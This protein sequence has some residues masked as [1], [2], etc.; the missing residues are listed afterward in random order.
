M[1][2][3]NMKNHKYWIA[4]GILIIIAIIILYPFS[5]FN[6]IKMN[7]DRSDAIKIAK[8]YLLQFKIQGE[9]VDNYDIEDFAVFEKSKYNYIQSELSGDQ[10][11]A[12]M[13]KNL[14]PVAMWRIMFHQNLPKNLSQYSFN[15]LLDAKGGVL[16][17]YRSIPDSVDLPAIT[18]DSA[19]ALITNDISSLFGEK[20]TGFELKTNK[21]SKQDRRIIHQFKWEKDLS[22]IDGTV[23]FSATVIGNK[24]GKLIYHFEIPKE[25]GSRFLAFEALFGTISVILAF[26]LTQFAF[27]IFIKKY[28]QGEVWLSLGR[29]LFI[30]Y[31][32]I[33]LIGLIN[34]YPS[35]GSEV[36]IG[37]LNLTM[38]KIIVFLSTGL[39]VYFVLSLLLFATWAVGESI[40]R[41]IWPD[42]LKAFDAFIKGKITS[43]HSGS[44]LMK[45]M[46]LGLGGNLIVLIYSI[47]L[48]GSKSAFISSFTSFKIFNGYLPALDIV[49]DAVTISLMSSIGITFFLISSTYNKWKNKWLS[50]LL[51]GIS[52]IL[53]TVI[54]YTPPSPQILWIGLLGDF[55][56]GIILA[57]IFFRFD[58]LTLISFIF[59]M[60]ISSRILALAAGTTAFYEINL[61]FIL[62][63]ALSVPVI[64]VISRIKKYEFVVENFGLPS[65][66]QKI[67]E[68]ERLRKEM[69]IA[70]KV[71]LSLLPKEQ[72]KLKNY[73]I[74][75]LS[76][77]AKEAGG[78]Y[79]DFVTLS[80]NK[81]GIAIGDVSGK[82]VGAAIYMTLT[83][84]ILQA[85]AEENI[86]PKNVLAKV[87]KLLYKT[88]EKNSFVSMFYSILDIDKHSLLY[89]RAGHNP[90]IF[91]S[92]KSEGAHYLMSKGIALGLEEGTIFTNTLNEETIQLEAG[93]VI[94]LYTD[95]FTE[96]MNEKREL[97]GE[98]RF[99]KLIQENKY[100][101]A[102]QILD[103]IL[104]EVHKFTGHHPQHDD[105]TIVVL[106]RIN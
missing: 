25:K 62:I 88:I 10:F 23:A 5:S 15:V 63:L 50:I 87:N 95:G 54:V 30:L 14:Y 37:T 68:R 92:S 17:F 86:S 79:Y 16:G 57:Y 106:K 72:P 58:L 47:A 56:F 76:I 102:Q 18:N 105:M 3:L 46:V 71:Q 93:D 97:Y 35:M 104:K 19:K 8:E 84:G 40:S 60:V 9:E 28:H 4:S 78:D 31:F 20:F 64:Y 41:T 85:H 99:T 39:L 66:V 52:V 2:E 94:V 61:A 65:H 22:T 103:L 21:E 33:S 53:Y 100:L 13:E 43:L 77:P 29:N 82:G 59:Y 26:F 38:T 80:E 70:S 11:R 90:A 1:N 89:A 34:Y 27:F 45:G 91:S 7:L 49:S 101:S 44:S 32:A 24:V 98:S 36:N 74:A 55:I 73:E 67:S 83:K 81:I 75:S 12:A 51:S 96:A 42:K 48:H 6:D 69:E